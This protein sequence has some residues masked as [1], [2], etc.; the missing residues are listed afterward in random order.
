MLLFDEIV[1]ALG[2]YPPDERLFDRLQSRRLVPLRNSY[3]R[4]SAMNSVI[5]STLIRDYKYA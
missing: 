2:R 4:I 5:M 3:S 1:G